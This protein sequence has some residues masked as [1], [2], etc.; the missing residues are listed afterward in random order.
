MLTNLCC[1]LA[2]SP[3]GSIVTVKGTVTVASRAFASSTFDQGFALQDKS[4]GIYVSLG[5]DVG[6]ELGDQGD[7]SFPGVA[8]LAR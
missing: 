3:E 6:L 8:F 2:T 4:G 1:P 5:T 7:L